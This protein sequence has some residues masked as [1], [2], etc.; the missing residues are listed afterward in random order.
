MRYRQA[1]NR[2]FILDLLRHV[3]STS[4]V[5]HGVSVPVRPLGLDTIPNR[6]RLAWAVLTGKADA[7]F[8]D[9]AT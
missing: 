9:E 4:T 1:P 2:W 8:W 7:V 3:E 6:V 5:V